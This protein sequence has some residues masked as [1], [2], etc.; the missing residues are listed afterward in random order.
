MSLPLV[1]LVLVAATAFGVLC[2][3]AVALVLPRLRPRLLALAPRRRAS[4]VMALLALPSVGGAAL[5]ILALLPGVASAIWPALDHC[6]QHEDQHFHLCLLHAPA[7]IDQ[8]VAFG[9]LA[10]A[11]VPVLLT[12]SVTA[13]RVRTGLRLLHALRSGTTQTQATHDVVPSDAP[14]AI[15]AG[16]WRP[17]VF[18]SAG[19]L[20]A[21]PDDGQQAVL[22]HEACH[23]QR[24]DPLRNLAAEVMAAW[25]LPSTRRTLLADLHLAVEELCDIAAAQRI[26]DRMTVASTLVAVG[27]L[28][29]QRPVPTTVAF[30]GADI[31]AR[32][33]TLLAPPRQDLA[34]PHAPIAAAFLAVGVAL[35]VPL[36]HLT[37]TLLTLVVG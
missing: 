17:R 7:A 37:E 22:A 33:R 5:A 29:Q 28:L 12:L 24:R 36:H 18:V 19:L 21:L 26:D 8:G 27:R 4:T 34:W 20:D 35:C 6:L 30:D 15:T 2:S 25:H 11:V 16:F 13:G 32:V 1:V 9:M 10:I 3:L 23:V 14:L 31:E